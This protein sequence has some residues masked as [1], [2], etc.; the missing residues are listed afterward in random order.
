VN[1]FLILG[2][3]GKVGRRL[4][5]LIQGQ[6]HSTRVASRTRGDVTFDWGDSATYD[7]ALTGVDGVFIVGPGSARDWTPQLA[8]FLSAASAAG[9]QHVVLLSARGVEFL[10]DGIVAKAEQTIEAGAV[11]WTILRPSH[12]SQ[13]FTEAMFVPVDGEIIAAVGHGAEPFIDADDIAEVAAAVLIEGSFI[14]RVVELSGPEALTFDA[15]V[16]V[17]NDRTGADAVFVDE[18]HDEHVERMR[19]AGTPELYIT[20]RMAMLDGIRS[21]RDER[22]SDGVETVLHRPATTFA[23]WAD[24]EVG[25]IR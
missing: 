14:G 24:R 7:P 10:P 12:F 22:V 13:N 20:W 16:A 8:T 18:S 17:L 21:G 11:P 15:A 5:S 23:S 25:S 2:G 4:V 1:T 3:T 6:G 9:V 19:A